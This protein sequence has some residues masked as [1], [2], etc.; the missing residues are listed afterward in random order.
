MVKYVLSIHKALGCIPGI[1]I[2]KE[3]APSIN[4]RRVVLG[5]WLT[6]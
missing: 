5:R 1:K 2:I 6:G 3:E 4:T